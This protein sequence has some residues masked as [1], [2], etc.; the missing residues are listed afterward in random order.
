MTSVELFITAAVAV[1]FIVLIASSVKLVRARTPDESEAAR[2]KITAAI[3]AGFIIIIAPPLVKWIT[4]YNGYNIDYDGDPKNGA[5][6]YYSREKLTT[7]EEVESAL[8]RGMALPTEVSTILD[9][10]INV[11]ML[12]GGVIVTIGVMWGA[13]EMRAAPRATRYALH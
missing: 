9:M 10:V 4:G 2:R 5:E 12:V 13:I 8:K 11:V 3:I 6:L 1:W 7:N